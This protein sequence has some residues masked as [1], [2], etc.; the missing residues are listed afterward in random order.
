MIAAV[1]W[2]TLLLGMQNAGVMED[3]E[4]E[5]TAKRLEL[6]GVALR[7]RAIEEA[8]DWMRDALEHVAIAVRAGQ[9]R[10]KLA[11]IGSERFD[12]YKAG[13]TPSGG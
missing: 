11:R 9:E 7:Q 10:N 8:A 13:K 3:I 4:I 5:R 12:R 2:P 1:E 6:A